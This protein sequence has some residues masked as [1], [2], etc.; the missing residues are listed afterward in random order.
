PRVSRID[1]FEQRLQDVRVRRGGVK[2]RTK[3]FEQHSKSGNRARIE[4]RQQELGVICLQRRELF[5]LTHLVAN[6][7][8]DIPQRVQERAQEVFVDPA[9][10][11]NQQ[12][13]VRV[14]T[15]M[16]S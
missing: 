12:V 1:Q 10:E 6:R 13:D 2:Q 5:E 14:E 9:P 16:A 8:A 15:Q 7:D 3:P 4:Q 11:Q